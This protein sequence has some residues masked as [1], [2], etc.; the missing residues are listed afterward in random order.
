[1]SEFSEAL[2]IVESK[3][4]APIAS[5]LFYEAY[6]Q[7][8]PSPRD[9]QILETAIRPDNWRQYVAIYTW[10]DGTEE[11]VGF[12]NY[13]KYKD[14][15]LEGGL[16]VRKNFYRRLS[17]E[18]FTDCSEHGGIAQ[19]IMETIATRLTDCVAWFGYVGDAKSLRVCL[20]VGYLQIDHPY[21]IVKWMQPLD[22]TVKRKWIDEITR[23]GPF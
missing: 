18:A 14:V 20:R 23:I 4:A 19:I 11:C 5:G 6:R 17:R 2:K 8:F 22:D 1:M 16:A 15:Y 12:C 9:Y 7:D 10:A 3:D 21:L 13:I